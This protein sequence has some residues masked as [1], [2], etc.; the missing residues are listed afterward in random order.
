M[1]PTLRTS[2]LLAQEVGATLPRVLYILRTRPHIR[3]AARAGNVR[4]YDAHAVAQV[5]YELNA[6]DARRGDRG[7]RAK[8]VSR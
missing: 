1:I 3:P 8:E 7:R 4:L 6:I 5:R 2:A